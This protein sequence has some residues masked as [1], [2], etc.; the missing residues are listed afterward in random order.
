MTL[1]ER[2]EKRREGKLIVIII[3]TN[4]VSMLEDPTEELSETDS[5][6]KLVMRR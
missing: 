5:E 3:Y 6:D 4:K 1:Y 2:E